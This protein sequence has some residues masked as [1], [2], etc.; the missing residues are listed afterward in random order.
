MRVL[1]I[2]GVLILSAGFVCSQE[3]ADATFTRTV[4]VNATALLRE[5]LNSRTSFSASPEAFDWQ[6]ETRNRLARGGF[7]LAEHNQ[8]KVFY[9]ERTEILH[10]SGTLQ[11]IEVIENILKALAVRLLL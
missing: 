4:K 10:V 5:D 8:V 2:L 1:T 6:Q 11:E 9:N 7:D 3:V